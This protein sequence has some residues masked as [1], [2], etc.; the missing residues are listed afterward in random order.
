MAVGEK[1]KKSV[2]ESKNLLNGALVWLDCVCTVGM[3]TISS[4]INQTNVTTCN[5][6]HIFPG[7]YFF[8]DPKLNFFASGD[9]GICI[10]LLHVGTPSW[11]RFKFTESWRP[12]C[13]KTSWPKMESTNDGG[14]WEGGKHDV[15]EAMP[16]PPKGTAASKAVFFRVRAPIH[17][18][19]TWIQEV[20]RPS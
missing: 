7:P 13:L 8:T 1:L 19:L 20:F 3:R 15:P 11:K 17:F 16:L 2:V 10:V 4:Q 18:K 6:H 12:P 5:Q 9:F 14:L